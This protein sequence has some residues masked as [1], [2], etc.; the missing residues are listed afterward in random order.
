MITGFLAY[1]LQRSRTGWKK[2]DSIITQLI[3]YV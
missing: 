3:V 1:H 2:T